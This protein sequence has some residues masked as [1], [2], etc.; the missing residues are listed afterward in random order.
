MQPDH[1]GKT[2]PDHRDAGAIATYPLG[3]RLAKCTNLFSDLTEGDPNDC[4]KG[5]QILQPCHSSPDEAL[6]GSEPP[7]PAFHGSRQKSSVWRKR[8]TRPP[9]RDPSRFACSAVA[10]LASSRRIPVGPWGATRTQRLPSG[11]GVSSTRVSQNIAVPCFGL[12]VVSHQQCD[13]SDVPVCHSVSDLDFYDVAI[14]ELELIAKFYISCNLY[15]C[16]RMMNSAFL[17]RIGSKNKRALP[18]Y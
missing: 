10:A 6:P 3:R 9:V 11:K 12:V 7:S 5:L 1:T 18:Q 13:M 14:L 8:K 2:V 4:H 16:P 17:I 15:D